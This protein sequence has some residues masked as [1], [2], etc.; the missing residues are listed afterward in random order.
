M[1]RDIYSASKSDHELRDFLEYAKL[2]QV[3]IS[4]NALFELDVAN[5]KDIID[6]ANLDGLFIISKEYVIDWKRDKTNLIPVEEK[7]KERKIE[8]PE[9]MVE[10]QK[11]KYIYAK[12]QDANIKIRH[13]LDVTNRISTRGNI[14]EFKDYFCDRFKN[15]GN[16]L[17]KHRTLTPINSLDLK[18]RI[19]K[20]EDVVLIGM[21][22]NK[23]IT[24][25][26]NVML[27]FD[28]E[29]GTFNVVVTQKD[30]VLFDLAK[31]VV[32]DDVVAV[33]GTKLGESIIIGTEIEYPDL[34]HKTY[35]KI[36]TEL[37]AIAI[38]DVH[39]GS[40]LFFGNE[41][42]KFIDW[43]SLK[44]VDDAE[45]DLVSKVK[46]LF[47]AGDIVDGIGIYPQ[48]LS[49]LQI[50]DIYEQFDKVAEFIQQIPDYIEIIIG[51][52]NHDPV[53]LADPQPAIAKEYAKKL[54][55]LRNVHFVGS[56]SWIEIEGLKTLLY[57]GNSMFSLQLALNLD[58][59]K[60]ETVMKEMLKRRDLAPIYGTR[61]P[62]LPEKGG[63]M[64]IK[65]EPDLFITGHIH[66]NGY[67]NYK[68]TVMVNPGTWQAQTIYQREQGH[69]PT[70]GRVPIIKL[71]SGKIQ[72]KIFIGE[73]QN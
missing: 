55:D 57:H 35:K 4:P 34:P 37:N 32:N 20:G 43:I 1:Q 30:T 31:N 29:V 7:Q 18:K 2:K 12:E 62:I 46:Y 22:L 5:Y 38:S 53:R 67:D 73:P 52:G 47:I 3:V 17:L 39:I 24:K 63:Y 58:P 25:N 27:S 40:K 71:N 19:G 13:E 51:S 69:H 70:P 60:P 65:E 54:Y 68:G 9:K 11:S 6:N 26:G 56:P 14:S 15:L 66:S 48:H 23:G 16:I 45:Y 49:E 42:Q 10:I 50:F 44:N 33:R 21:L 64:L 72:E 28:D 36:D 8:L 59:T 41:F 61:H